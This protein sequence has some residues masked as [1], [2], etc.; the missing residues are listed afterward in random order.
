MKNKRMSEEKI[1]RISW[2]ADGSNTIQKMWWDNGIADHTFYYWRCKYGNM[3]VADARR[4]RELES[5]N[6]EL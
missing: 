3:E 5:E 2:D 1:I 6:A 4:L